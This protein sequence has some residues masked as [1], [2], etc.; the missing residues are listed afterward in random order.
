MFLTNIV[1]HGRHQGDMA[2]ALNRWRHPVASSEA[3]DV[4]HRTMR[5]ASYRQTRMAIEITSNLP[6]FVVVV[7]SL[8]AHNLS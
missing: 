8:F 4:L 2:Q 3:P 5:P 6:A 1:D 7:D